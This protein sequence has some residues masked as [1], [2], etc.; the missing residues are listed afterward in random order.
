MD[1]LNS[2]GKAM[3]NMFFE[4]RD[5]ELLNKLRSELEGDRKL[6][7][8]QAASGITDSAVLKALTDQGVT[9]E[10][11][12]AL[13]LIPLVTV[14]WSDGTLDAKEQEAILKAAESSGVAAGS[15]AASLL[16]SWLV[17]K[18]Q[19]TLLDAWK[20]YIG[21]LKTSVDDAAF[22]QVKTSIL[23]RAQNVAQ[24]A[25]GFLGIGSVSDSEKQAI[26]DLESAFG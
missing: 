17:S 11:L 2:R 23:N 20:A 22:G 7:V 13:S 15:T 21:A 12:S 1:D 18:P 3:E 16:E 6:E 8:L 26:A 24:A 25:G 9:A 19:A 10:S 5:Q 14:A 4:N